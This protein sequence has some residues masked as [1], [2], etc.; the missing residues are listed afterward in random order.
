MLLPIQSKQPRRGRQAT[1]AR[2]VACIHSLETYCA[3]NLPNNKCWQLIFACFVSILGYESFS[4]KVTE[5]MEKQGISSR[6][7]LAIVSYAFK[8]AYLLD[9]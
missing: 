4:E 7:G 6:S 1:D 9:F 8:F 3:N 5:F 2:R